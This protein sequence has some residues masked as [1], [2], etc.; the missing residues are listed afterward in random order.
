MFASV[1]QAIHLK[2]EFD[3]FHERILKKFVPTRQLVKLRVEKYERVQALGEP[4]SVYVQ[5]IKDVAA[6][7][8]IDEGEK[9]MV[10]RIVDGLSPTQ[11]A[12]FVFQEPPLSFAQ[13]DR[14]IAIDRNVAYADS[15]RTEQSMTFQ[16]GRVEV[17]NSFSQGQ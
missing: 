14:L 9:E 8:R 16:V 4:L 11:T 17:K 7:L 12:R 10:S 5:A 13:L 2:E 15:L 6:V 1:T 3:V